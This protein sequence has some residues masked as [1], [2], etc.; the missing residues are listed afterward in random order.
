MDSAES[1][2]TF[3]MSRSG[4]SA[5]WPQRLNRAWL[6]CAI[7]MGLLSAL[8][9]GVTA[10]ALIMGDWWAAAGALG[11]CVLLG[12]LGWIGLGMGG[13]QAI[14]LSRRITDCDDLH[15]Q[16]TRIPTRCAGAL[17]FAVAL[18]GAGV[19]GIVASGSYFLG[20]ASSLLPEGRGTDGNA[21]LLGILGLVALLAALCVI[22]FRPRG[23]VRIYSSGVSRVERRPFSLR[24]GTVD[25]YRD[26]GDI[27]TVIA[28]EMVIHSGG[29]DVRHPMIKLRTVDPIEPKARTKFD[30]D[31]E[32]TILAKMY[33]A[34]P[35]M[36]FELLHRMSETPAARS[37]VGTPA[38]REA[39]RPPRLRARLGIDR[40][41]SAGNRTNRLV[42]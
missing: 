40:S 8:G 16:G 1:E 34:E 17:T 20:S 13:I 23:E 19:Y 10:K 3:D 33:V 26:W 9:V 11:A 32:L 15:G 12:G 14:G 4:D 28:D 21:T 5:P 25:T 30:S 38:A 35:N 42:P 7:F 22:V 18:G 24:A 6:A 31:R 36:L 41:E 39:L 2:S 27:E 29:V 37:I